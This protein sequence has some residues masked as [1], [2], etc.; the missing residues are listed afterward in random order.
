MANDDGRQQ[1]EDAVDLPQLTIDRKSYGSEVLPGPHVQRV[2]PTANC[3]DDK[4]Q[5]EPPQCLA[6]LAP[7]LGCG[8]APTD[9]AEFWKISRTNCNSHK[10]VYVPHG[11]VTIDQLRNRTTGNITGWPVT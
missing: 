6:E 4:S 10:R 7:V 3:S 9:I 11:C 5:P 8:S 2:L 1:N